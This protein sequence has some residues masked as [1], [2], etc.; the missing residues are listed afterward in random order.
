MSVPASVAHYDTGSGAIP[1]EGLNIINIGL[2][3]FLLA[4]RLH[5]SACD[6]EPSLFICFACLGSLVTL[7]GLEK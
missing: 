2:S 7:L 6:D 1:H 4:S 5:A 3:R